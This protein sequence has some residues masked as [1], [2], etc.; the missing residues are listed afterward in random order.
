MEEVEIAEGST[1]STDREA[2]TAEEIQALVENFI[3]FEDEVAAFEVYDGD[4]Y[5]SLI[6]APND[7]FTPEDLAINRTV[8]FLLNCSTMKDGII[9]LWSL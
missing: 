2:I 7:L 1:V 4:I 8:K 6:M 5:I 9:S 3:G